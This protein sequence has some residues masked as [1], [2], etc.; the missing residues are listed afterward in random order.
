MS[1]IVERLR[2]ATLDIGLAHD[3]ADRIE[4]LR[5]EN[6]RLRAA[7]AEIARQNKTS[8]MLHPENADIEGGFDEVIDV[9]R[10][11]LGGGDE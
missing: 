4:A 1:D 5:A 11:A 2:T 6:D 8:E 3:A 7:L 9:A 10:A